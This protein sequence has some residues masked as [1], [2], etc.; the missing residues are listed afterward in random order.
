MQW[1]VILHICL[2]GEILRLALL[3]ASPYSGY[4][5]QGKHKGV[6]VLLTLDP[7]R[8]AEWKEMA[9][10]A[11]MPVATML[12]ETLDMAQPSIAEVWKAV[13]VFKDEPKELDQAMSEIMGRVMWGAI[14]D[15]KK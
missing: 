10:A 2:T 11:E 5:P 1:L 12:R 8:Y 4:M 7:E 13:R 15:I 3:T 6:R 9:E 14:K